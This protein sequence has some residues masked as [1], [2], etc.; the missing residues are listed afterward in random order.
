MNKFILNKY[1]LFIFL[2]IS[3]LLSAT[4]FMYLNLFSIP[5]VGTFFAL[6]M[7]MYLYLERMISFKQTSGL[8]LPSIL[9]FTVAV[10]I[11]SMTYIRLLAF[12]GMFASY[13]IVRS[14]QKKVSFTPIWPV[15]LVG[16]ISGYIFQYFF[17]MVITDPMYSFLCFTIWQIA[18]GITICI[19]IAHNKVEISE[20]LIQVA[21]IKVNVIDKKI[22]PLLIIVTILIVTFGI[23]VLTQ[24]LRISGQ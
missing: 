5:L 23:F 14:V 3:G 13:I 24:F 4:A 2:L 9:A 1:L 6:A 17:N 8:I 12:S 22:F 11:G 18:V 21:P 7:G 10:I 15:I 19:L 20:P 16:A